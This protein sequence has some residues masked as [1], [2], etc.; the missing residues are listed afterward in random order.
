MI[1]RYFPGLVQGDWVGVMPHMY[2]GEDGQYVRID[3]IKPL[4][5]ALAYNFLDLDFVRS[6]KYEKMLAA[7][8]ELRSLEDEE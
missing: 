4:I 1:K 3:D 7:V 5:T 8:Y 6:D 2:E